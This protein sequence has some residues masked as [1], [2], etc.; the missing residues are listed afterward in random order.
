MSHHL[1][2]SE[3]PITL[4]YLYGR[5]VRLEAELEPLKL[6]FARLD[7][8]NERIDRLTTEVEKHTTQ[9]KL[10]TLQLKEFGSAVGHAN[11]II[12]PEDWEDITQVKRPELQKLRHRSRQLPLVGLISAAL[13]ELV[14]AIIEGRITFHHW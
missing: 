2:G 3:E 9:F 12:I 11:R 1:N 13:V 5:T 4:D 10:F 8:T 6:E 7:G 14:R